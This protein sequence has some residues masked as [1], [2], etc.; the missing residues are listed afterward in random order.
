MKTPLSRR[1]FVGTAAAALSI[2]LLPGMAAAERTLREVAVRAGE[3]PRGIDDDLMEVTIARLHGLYEAHRYTAAEVTR[4]YLARIV[5]YNG[6]YRA[7]SHVDATGA[8]ARASELDAG[9]G[10]RR[11]DFTA[12]P[13]W[14][15]PIVIKANTSVRGLVTSAG[16]WGYVLPGLELVAPSDALVA[17]KLRAAGAII[18]GQTNMP[19]FAASDTTFSTAYGRT[20][21]AYNVRCSPGGSSGGT[22]TSVAANLCVLGTGTD[23][24]NS[25]RMPAGTSSLVGILPTRGL[26]SIAG[27]QPLD[28]LRDNTGPI[29]RDV[30]DAVTA[31]DVMA[32]PDPL[33]ARTEE[34]KTRAQRGPYVHYLKAGALQGKRFGVPAFN[35][36]PQPAG[37]SDGRFAYLHPDTRAL[38]MTSVAEIRRAGATVVFDDALLPMSF[39][40]LVRKI[41][42]GPYRGEGV[43]TFLEH[44][45]S[46]YYHSS[47]EYAQ[48]VGTM[49]PAYIRGAMPRP[50][51]GAGAGA[52]AGAPAPAL[53]LERDPQAKTRYYEPRQNALDVFDETLTRF[54]LDGYVYPAIQMPPNDEL[55]D[56][57]DGHQSQGPHSETAWANPIGIPAVVVPGGFYD[58]GLPFG[59]EFSTGRWRDGDLLAWAFAYEQATKHRRVPELVATR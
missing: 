53:P 19:D 18:L 4:W 21:N 44:F 5:R 14:G 22:V 26:T 42:T 51:N 49:I 13:L 29:A 46:P 50:E 24:G 28:W 23:T 35:M 27:I 36:L 52:G 59:I 58:G 55:Q 1:D 10:R 16:W 15:V 2:P 9:I 56:L 17:A 38:F 11:P 43:E 12:H 31:L 6:V 45:G 54:N 40:E 33:D 41:E 7:V 37:E 47:D 30:T 39:I 32:A 34:S 25:I 57:A 8:L 20:G 3:L 48:A